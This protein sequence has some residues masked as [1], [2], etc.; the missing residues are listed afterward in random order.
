KIR[1][2]FGVTLVVGLAVVAHLHERADAERHDGEDCGDSESFSDSEATDEPRQSFLDPDRDPFLRRLPDG[3]RAS[4]EANA[5]YRE[6]R[7]C[8]L[9]SGYTCVRWWSFLSPDDED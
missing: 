4:E 9:P 8:D 3:Q 6:R 1:V 7:G 5:R 2:A